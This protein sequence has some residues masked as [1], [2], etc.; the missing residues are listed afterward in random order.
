MKE[1]KIGRA[2][3]KSRLH[4][5]VKTHPNGLPWEFGQEFE[6]KPFLNGR[7]INTPYFPID[8]WLE[9]YNAWIE[10]F[11]AKGGEFILQPSDNVFLNED[12]ESSTKATS[13]IVGKPVK[14]R[15]NFLV[16]YQWKSEEEFNM[17]VKFFTREKV[18]S[19]DWHK[20]SFGGSYFTTLKG[21]ISSLDSEKKK[22]FSSNLKGKNWRIRNIKTGEIFI[23][24]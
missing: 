7:L 24:E 14:E 11:E 23:Y 15:K 8:T 1:N 10:V 20:N 3:V 6:Y 21:A 13:K 16:E 22:F 4:E 17:R 19:T 2:N 5:W 18:Y 9:D 12:I